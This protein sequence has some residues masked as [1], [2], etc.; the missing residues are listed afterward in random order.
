MNECALFLRPDQR[1][2]DLSREL[3]AFEVLIV[4]RKLIFSFDSARPAVTS[5]ADKK[6]YLPAGA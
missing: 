2:S 6:I 1:R 4:N 5:R 3:K